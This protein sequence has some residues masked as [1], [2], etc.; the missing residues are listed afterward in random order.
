MRSARKASGADGREGR[1]TGKVKAVKRPVAYTTLETIGAANAHET[2]PDQKRRCWKDIGSD[3]PLLSVKMLAER[4]GGDSSCSELFMKK[5]QV[6]DRDDAA[7]K[8]AAPIVARGFG[9]TR[10]DQEGWDGR[11]KNLVERKTAAY[12]ARAV[13]RS[14]R[15]DDSHRQP[16]V[17]E[18]GTEYNKH[19]KNAEKRRKHEVRQ[20]EEKAVDWEKNAS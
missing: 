13:D 15:R 11:K 1:D 14:L 7:G 10:K 19:G 17:H 8:Q 3:T 16:T 18:S 4:L 12:N 9:K 2:R 20:I 6:T 5:A